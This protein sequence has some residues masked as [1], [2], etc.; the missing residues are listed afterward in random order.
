MKYEKIE[1][2]PICECCNRPQIEYEKLEK[3]SMELLNLIKQ[4]ASKILQPY[5]GV[6]ADEIAYTAWFEEQSYF[7]GIIEKVKKEIEKRADE[8]Q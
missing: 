7:I 3:Y 4:E 6:Y 1:D 8:I 2:L 5:S